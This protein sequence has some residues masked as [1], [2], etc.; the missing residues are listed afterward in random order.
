M[1]DRMSNFS[2]LATLSVPVEMPDGSIIGVEVAAVG[3]EQVASNFL[4]FQPVLQT[5]EKLVAAIAIPIEKSK[6]HKATV[7]F[8]LEVSV[9][10]GTLVTTLVKGNGK[11]NLEIVLEWQ[12]V[13]SLGKS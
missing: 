9:S 12:S 4:P 1:N 11:A 2:D 3:R 5:L 13:D 6:P 10:E 8:G 7:K